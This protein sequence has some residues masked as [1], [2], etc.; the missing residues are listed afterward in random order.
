MT[1]LLFIDLFLVMSLSPSYIF[2]D[3]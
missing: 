2:Q 3:I 1:P